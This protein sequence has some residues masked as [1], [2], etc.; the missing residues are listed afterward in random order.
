MHDINILHWTPHFK[1]DVIELG[2]KYSEHNEGQTSTQ[3]KTDKAMS[4]FPVKETT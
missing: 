4:L 3:R 2:K 1:R